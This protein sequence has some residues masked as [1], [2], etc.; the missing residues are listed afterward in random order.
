MHKQNRGERGD[1]VRIREREREAKW[2]DIARQTRTMT[3]DW[4]IGR[5]VLDES[6]PIYSCFWRYRTNPY[7]KSDSS[8]ALADPLDEVL[9]LSLS[10]TLSAS[11]PSSGGAYLLWLRRNVKLN[12]SDSRSLFNSLG[13][14]MWI[15]SSSICSG[16]WSLH[17][18]VAQ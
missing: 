13:M 6:L 3:R 14:A 11:P 7:N 1:V 2:R 15:M 9:S 16:S 10:L 5:L 17:S 18:T 4:Q 12:S 8:P